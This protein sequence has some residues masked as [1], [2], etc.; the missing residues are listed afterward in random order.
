MRLKF[1]LLFFLPII[2]SS[3]QTIGV[4]LNNPGS[5]NGL[6]LFNPLGS[7]TTY[8]IDNCG[9]KVY[10]WNSEY[11]PAASVY[12]MENGNLLRTNRLDSTSIAFGGSAGR[13]EILDPESN[14]LWHY[15][16]NS[17]SLVSHHDV[18]LLPNGNILAIV[19]E[20]KSIQETISNV[21]NINDSRYSE[22]IIE[23]NPSTNE[24]VWE[25]DSWD[26]LVQDFDSTLSNYGDIQSFPNRININYAY[27]GT[28]RD[29]LHVNSIDYNEDL[30]QIIINTPTF[31]EFWI[32]DHSTTTEEASGSIG[33]TSGKGGD[34]LYRWGNPEAYNRGD[35]TNQI[36]EY[37]HDAHWIPPG[38]KDSGK[39]MVF[40][41]GDQR[42][43]SSVD[44]LVPPLDTNNGNY[45]IT[46]N[47]PY[48]PLNLFYSYSDSSNFY[49][50][51]VSGAQQQPN[52]N[53]LICSGFQGRVFEVENE[54]DSIVW[55]YILP[56]NNFGPISQGD[57]ALL[58]F[59]FRTE[60]FST[61]YTAFNNLNLEDGSPIELDP[62][63]SSCEIY[64]SGCTD[65][66]A[67]NYNPEANFNDN[68]CSYNS[69]EI[70]EITI[71]FGD[72]YTVDESTYSQTGTY[73]DSLIT[74]NGCDSVITTNLN[75]ITDI[76][77]NITQNESYL[78]STATGG[79]PPYTYLWNT[80]DTT[81]TLDLLMDGV[82][83]VIVSDINNCISDTTF[84]SID[85]SSIHESM[86]NQLN[87]YP[88]PSTG[89]INITFASKAKG[90]INII[91]YNLIG[92]VV[93]EQSLFEF[94]GEFSTKINI[95]KKNKSMYILEIKSGEQSIKRKLIV[96][97]NY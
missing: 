33:G 85:W 75:V 56:V 41:N 88:N 57:T 76:E 14:V 83:W 51:R 40:N 4:F 28:D 5:Y 21:S 60:R 91:L 68:T 46:N 42:L 45:F 64:I 96:Q 31:G 48:G 47:S 12:L 79:I 7:P 34:I 18:E 80:G 73:I 63:T 78:L 52:G 55:D 38:L 23:I 72:N 17:D 71:C 44:I 39:I 95:N 16:M 1:I 58:N 61:D 66:F 97:N 20:H 81:Q 36:F 69:N 15:E 90:E 84:Y 43:Y 82:Y 92:K 74:I 86:L 24:I 62:L 3:Q 67:C 27:D 94:F 35:S 8:L 70:N 2:V 77:N 93:F 30:N 9:N 6:T 54:T 10:E 49:S 29:W 65:S 25:W 59:T 22:K 50:R 11:S 89:L 13:I 87:V 19:A 37:Q 32:I 53:I 26:H